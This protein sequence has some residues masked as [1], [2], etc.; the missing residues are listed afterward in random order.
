MVFKKT[1]RSRNWK[2]NDD[3]LWTIYLRSISF[4]TRDAFKLLPFSRAKTHCKNDKMHFPPFLS[5]LSAVTID[6]ELPV[7]KWLKQDFLGLP[8]GASNIAFYW[9]GRD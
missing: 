4:G 7:F 5:S 1:Y 2:S 9:V 8:P 3:C 6:P